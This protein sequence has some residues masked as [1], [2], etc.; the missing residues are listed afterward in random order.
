MIQFIK[1]VLWGVAWCFVWMFI[2][3][4]RR[5]RTNCLRWAINK[6]ASDGGYLVVRWCRSNKSGF[7]VWPHLLWLSAEDGKHLHHAVPDKD[8]LKKHLFPSPWF[9]PKIKHGDDVQD[10]S[11]N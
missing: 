9:T 3:P 2:A 7:I 6:F 4:F 5:G 1:L 11:E 10:K 8:E